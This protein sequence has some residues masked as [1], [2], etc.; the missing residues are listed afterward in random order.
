MMPALVRATVVVW[1]IKVVGDKR[2]V[3]YVKNDPVSILTDGGALDASAI[4]S[5]Y[6]LKLP[7][8]SPRPDNE[9]LQL[10]QASGMGLLQVYDIKSTALTKPELPSPSLDAGQPAP[11]AKPTAGRTQ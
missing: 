2:V 5:Q 9:Q 10:L 4:I 6:I 7:N 1:E 3:S 8:G 11:T